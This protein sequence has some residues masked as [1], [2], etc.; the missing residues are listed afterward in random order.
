LILYTDLIVLLQ[1]LN[2]GN[3]P[4]SSALIRVPT[5]KGATGGSSEN[6]PLFSFSS[7][8]RIRVLNSSRFNHSLE[9]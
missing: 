9:S 6:A 2:S 7:A 1:F 5:Q 8:M 3:Y 4:C